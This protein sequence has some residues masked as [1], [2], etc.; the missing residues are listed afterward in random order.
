MEQS[1]WIPSRDL[2][3]I[4]IWFV[5]WN[6]YWCFVSLF[7]SCFTYVAI[8]INSKRKLV[9]LWHVIRKMPLKNNNI[10]NQ[11]WCLFVF[12]TIVSNIIRVPDF[13]FQCYQSTGKRPGIRH[14]KYW[15]IG[16]C[17]RAMFCIV[18]FVQAGIVYV[19]SM[20][21]SNRVNLKISVY[22]YMSN[23]PYCHIGTAGNYGCG[24]VESD[25]E[26]IARLAKWSPPRRRPS[27]GS[28]L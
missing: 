13:W 18:V 7:L 1:F 9:I 12:L 23:V 20:T 5:A 17:L 21:K 3:Y 6:D 24:W 14:R 10:I 2:Q 25:C 16:S 4:T 11:S 8:Q 19:S 26:S 15:N 22:M 28:L 27:S